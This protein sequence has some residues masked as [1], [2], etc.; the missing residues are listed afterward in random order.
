MHILYKWLVRS[1]QLDNIIACYKYKF[2]SDTKV[3]KMQVKVE[4]SFLN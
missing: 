2:G 1:Q 3:G 4:I